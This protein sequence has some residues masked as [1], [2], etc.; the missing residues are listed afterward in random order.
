MRLK[1]KTKT[2]DKLTATRRKGDGGKAMPFKLGLEETCIGVPSGT[3][4]SEGIRFQAYVSQDRGLYQRHPVRRRNR[5]S[6]LRKGKCGNEAG[7]L[8]QR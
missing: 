6:L 5:A 2:T 3:L 4:S 8:R 1:T 7:E